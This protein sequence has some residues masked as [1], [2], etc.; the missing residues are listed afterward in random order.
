[1]HVVL[2]KYAYAY[3]LRNN[4]HSRIAQEQSELAKCQSRPTLEL[5]ECRT[6]PTNIQC[7]TLGLGKDAR[8]VDENT[9]PS[10]VMSCDSA[11]HQAWLALGM[12]SGAISAS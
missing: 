2:R 11:D 12:N 5:A 4:V 7:E 6:Q 3:A 9:W 8:L 1:M 10:S